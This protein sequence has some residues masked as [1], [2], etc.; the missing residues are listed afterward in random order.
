MITPPGVDL[1]CRL[2]Q[3]R[4]SPLTQIALQHVVSAAAVWHKICSKQNLAQIRSRWPVQLAAHLGASGA[5]RYV[6]IALPRRGLFF[7][8]KSA[9][10][11]S[12]LTVRKREEKQETHA[13]LSIGC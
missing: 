4:V 10:K 2:P 6:R 9:K 7:A 3:F 11:R 5:L 12:A 1:R 8:A 13:A